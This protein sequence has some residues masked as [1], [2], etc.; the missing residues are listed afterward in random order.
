[1]GDSIVEFIREYPDISF[2][3]K[4]HFFGPLA[5]GSPSIFVDAVAKLGQN[6]AVLCGVG[7][8]DFGRFFVEKLKRDGVCCDYIN[9]VKNKTT[10]VAFAVYYSDGSRE[11][12]FHF[13]NTPVIMPDL[14]RLNEIE[15]PIFFHLM[16]CSLMIN[17]LFR[18]DIISTANHFVKKGAKLTLDPNIRH[19]ILYGR[20]IHDILE[21]LLAN[22]SILLP[23]QDE[24]LQL[25]EMK[26]VHEAVEKLWQYPVLEIIAVKMGASGS[27][28]FTRN[29]QFD[30]GVYH[31]DQVDPTGAGDNYDAG[32]LCGLLEARSLVDCAKL[33]SAAAALCTGAFGPMEAD[34]D[35]N[36]LT[37]IIESMPIDLKY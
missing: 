1:M 8:D 13:D 37:R 11:F 7:D 29:E 36:T 24:L 35:W 10:G 32:F 18:Q 19:N 3:Q 15:T 34:Y 22:V 28:V 2:L 27:R 21:P 31:V 20:K 25:T 14:S 5:S 33:G 6:A 16:G 26:S 30:L 12:I 4:G 23:G 9:I 17:D